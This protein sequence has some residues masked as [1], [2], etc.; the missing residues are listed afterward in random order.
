MP[1]YECAKV[2]VYSELFLP[3]K[4]FDQL[5]DN[6]KGA[7][8]LM[9]AA[10]AF[11]LMAALI[12]LAGTRLHVT[13]ILLVR[14]TCML[15]MLSPMLVLNFKESITTHRLDLQLMRITFALI[16][17]L[18]GFTA[19]I[20]MP[21]ADATAI[22]FAKSFFVT[23]FAVLI[24]RETVGVF[25]WGAV[26]IGFLGVLIMLRPGSESFSIYGVFAVVGAAAAGIVMVIIR[27][28]SRTEAPATI[29]LYQSFGVAIVMI[30]P[31]T[32][33]WQQPLWHE[34]L[35]LI[36]IGFVS[37]FA[38]KANIFAYKWGEASLLASLDY[39]RLIY[40]TILGYLIFGDLPDLYTWL[41]ASIIICAS[42]FTIH[43][44]TV[45]KQKIAASADARVHGD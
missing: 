25:R 12:K 3:M 14:Q 37:Y 10:A 42:I 45:K 24:L 6:V 11:S 31:A 23:I 1:L 40:A 8:V 18:F 26:A 19:L 33:F 32:W 36:A 13:Q 28:L 9:F 43:R 39:A 5:P 21:L 29:L 41:G 44:E 22:A 7:V 27:L 4:Q 34:W 15:L 17:M 2:A 16:A 30:I 35:L 38:Q 20:K